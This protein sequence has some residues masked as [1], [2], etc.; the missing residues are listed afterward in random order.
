MTR[1]N[2]TAADAAAAAAADAVVAIA[3]AGEAVAAAASQSAPTGVAELPLSVAD[4]MAAIVAAT[5]TSSRAGRNAPQADP[6][7]SLPKSLTDAEI[8]ALEWLAESAAKKKGNGWKFYNDSRDFNTVTMGAAPKLQ[9]TVNL[10]TCTESTRSSWV[11]N[12]VVVALMRRDGQIWI[13]TFARLCQAFKVVPLSQ[14]HAATRIKSVTNV[15]TAWQ[16]GYL[17]FDPKV[18]VNLPQDPMQDIY[19]KMGTAILA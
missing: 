1:K 18:A 13:G 15:P 11:F 2:T 17:K 5:A 7:G 19:V 10:T 9:A 12:N 8:K 14:S 4:L 6:W 3:A 16:S